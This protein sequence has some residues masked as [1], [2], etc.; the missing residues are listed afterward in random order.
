[1]GVESN[2]EYMPDLHGATVDVSSPNKL[3]P[4]S[5]ISFFNSLLDDRWIAIFKKNYNA[6]KKQMS[7][8]KK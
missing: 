8:A 5:I 4:N 7:K 1:M 2:E 6:V 3:P